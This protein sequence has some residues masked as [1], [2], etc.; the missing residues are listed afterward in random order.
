MFLALNA[1]GD[2][3]HAEKLRVIVLTDISSEPDDQMSLVRFL[4]Y[5][6]EFDV[7]GII[8]TTS[9]WRQKDPDI[10][11]IHEVIDAYGAAYP[12]LMAHADGFLRMFKTIMV[13]WGR[14][15]PLPIIFGKETHP[16][17]SIWSLMD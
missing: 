11:T 5:S 10:A 13:R 9:C 16:R 2:E 6:N 7:E 15:T 1:F 8:A 12:N 4:T 17:F 14:C 3:S